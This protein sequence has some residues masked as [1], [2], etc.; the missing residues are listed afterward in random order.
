[1]SLRRIFSEEEV[2]AMRQAEDLVKMG[3]QAG[4][5]A[6]ERLVENVVQIHPYPAP[7]AKPFFLK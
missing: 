2:E 5:I 4:V 6:V 7:P 3:L 1:M